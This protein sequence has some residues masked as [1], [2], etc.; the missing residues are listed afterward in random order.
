M[1]IGL[2]VVHHE[3]GLKLVCGHRPLILLGR[4]GVPHDSPTK[5]PHREGCSSGTAFVQG[6]QRLQNGHSGKAYWRPTRLDTMLRSARARGTLPSGGQAEKRQCFSLW[7][8]ARATKGNA[9]DGAKRQR[10]HRH[11]MQ[12]TTPTAEKR[13]PGVTEKVWKERGWR[14]EGVRR[15][16]IFSSFL[17]LV[18]CC[19]VFCCER[20]SQNLFQP[21][22]QHIVLITV[23]LKANQ[24]DCTSCDLVCV[25]SD[26]KR[27]S[28]SP[29]TQHIFLTSLSETIQD[30]KNSLQ[31][32]GVLASVTC[33]SSRPVYT[34]RT[35][36]Q[37][38]VGRGARLLR[39]K[40]RGSCREQGPA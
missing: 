24:S 32:C 15:A 27:I 34:E 20:L 33:I 6:L 21:C 9:P 36:Q 14:R 8:P 7:S 12:T 38:Q 35:Y 2:R 26:E 4:V 30:M 13:R 5:R 19:L 10:R 18:S 37:P 16:T 39:G 40:S 28:L 22:A 29:C 1:N 23:W 25:S 17:P 3:P 11:V 31:F